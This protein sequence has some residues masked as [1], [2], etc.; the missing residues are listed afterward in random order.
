MSTSQGSTRLLVR[1]LATLAVFAMLATA[2]GSSGDDDSAGGDT[3]EEVETDDGGGDD[4]GGDDGGDADD[5]E[6]AMED[7][8]EEA[9][10]DDAMADGPVSGGDLSVLLEAESDTWDI[11]GANCAVS[12][13]S[14][15]NSV[16]DNLTMINENNEVEPFLLESYEPNADFTE[17]TLVM[18]DGVTFHD[19]T[20]ADGAAVQRSLTEM[21]SGLLQGQVFLDLVNGP[22]SIVLVDDMT[23]TVTFSV[24][25]ATFGRN[26]A[27]RTGWLIAPSFWDNPERAGALM[28]GTGP[29]VMDEWSRDEQTVLSR[30]EDYWRSDADGNQLPYLDSIT[31]RPVPDV[32]TRRATME[33]GDADVNMDSFGE[34]L[35]FWDN[36]W[37][38]N[39][40]PLPASRETT[41]LLLNNSVPPFDNPDFRRAI[42]LC[43]DRDEYL[44]FRAP[45]NALANGPFA[46]GDLGFIDDPGFPAFDPAA[47][48][49]LLDEIGRPEELV[50]GTTNVPSNLLTAELFADQWSTN[51]GLNVNID[52]FDQSELITKAI[53]G[54]FE[55]FLWR[56]HGQA[57]PG[58][59]YIWWH[60]RHAAGLALNFGRI[61]DTDLDALLQQTWATEDLGELDSIAQDINRL[62]A[63]NVNNIW[64]NTTEWRLPY[65]NGVHNVNGLTLPSGSQAQTGIAGRLTLE[66]T[67]MG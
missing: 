11:P 58:L 35:D 3:G 33:S 19:G 40:A 64:L 5:E 44:A 52:Q 50:Y 8:D 66:E 24:P 27:G 48:S 55:V 29:F 53:G 2:C 16:T 9:M 36:E 39:L 10:E 60:S 18:R 37:D 4:D 20:P 14:V 32:S 25:F 22:E 46:E 31:Y 62:F 59:E 6:E 28:V 7:E 41:Y 21:A 63:E 38:G 45:G 34:N 54:A 23:V 26:L 42:A 61:V 57:H 15:M 13:I 12:C 67:W 1:L 43:T 65:V 30:N 49:A 51:C 17:F 56:N 47:G